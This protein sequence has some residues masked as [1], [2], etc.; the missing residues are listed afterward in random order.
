MNVLIEVNPLDNVKKTGIATYIDFLCRALLDEQ[1][2]DRFTFW[3]PDVFRDPFPEYTNKTFIGRSPYRRDIIE[4]LWKRFGTGG[5]PV[6][7]DVY[8]VPVPL[9]P[10]IPRGKST[11]K[12]VATIYD[13]AFARYPEFVTNAFFFRALSERICEQADRAEK[14][15]VISKSCGD[16]LQEI[17]KIPKEKI[18]V[19]YPGCDLKRPD[20]TVSAEQQAELDRLRIPPRYLLCVGTWE[21]RKNLPTLF[22]A[23]SRLKT[24]L[25]EEDLY[26]CISGIKGWKFQEA[27]QR[28][29]DLGIADRV[30]TLGHVPREWLPLLYARAQMFIYPSY[31]EGFG[32][33]VLEAMTCGTPVITTNVS[34]LPEAAGDAGLLFDPYSVEALCGHIE[35]LLDDPELRE[36]LVRKGF[37]HAATFSWRRAAQEHLALYREVLTS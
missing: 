11:P 21:P 12:I 15:V 28:I 1:T 8:H 22:E 25:R 10:L 13:L 3:G 37:K 23:I 35:R 7:P 14:I 19:S 6:Q 33:P 31:Y 9:C 34:S 36:A 20:S 29:R 27:E 18:V 2:G 4:M 24:R 32:L 16:D 30:I 26:L 17:L 5:L